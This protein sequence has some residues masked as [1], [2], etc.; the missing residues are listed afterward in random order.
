[1]YDVY[2][3]LSFIASQLTWLQNDLLN[4]GSKTKVLFY[5]YDFKHELNL[6]SLGIDMALWGHIH[7]DAGDISS[8]PYDLSTDNVCDGTRAYRVIRVN[9]GNLQPE[10]TIYTHSDGDMLSINYNMTNNGTLDSLSATIYNK[11]GLSFANGLIKFLMPLS[12]S[13]YTVFNGSLE[14]TYIVDSYAVCYVKVNIPANQNITVTIVKGK[15]N[16]STTFI[17][18]FQIRHITQNYPN[19]FTEYTKINF[20]LTQI[21]NTNLCVYD[22]SGKLIDVLLNEKKLPGIYSIIWDGTD[23]NGNGVDSGI[24]LYKFEVNEKL[25]D[26]K[27][28]IYIK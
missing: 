2:G 7:S 5:H 14:Q 28:M 8:H 24:Y 26:T 25:A 17:D 4:A 9:G 16:G 18:N 21:A 10:N 15:G 22:M 1:M 12:D 27:Q 11:H 20:K 6:S 23:C 19:P 3:D 13:G